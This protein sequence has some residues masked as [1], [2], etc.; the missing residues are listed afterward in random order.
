MAISVSSDFDYQKLLDIMEGEEEAVREIAMVFIDD[1]P[2]DL[3]ALGHAVNE[4]DY[5]Q[6]KYWAHKLKSSVP[7]FVPEPE[8]NAP[9]ALE[10]MARDQ[11]PWS[12]IETHYQRLYA[13][14]QRT[15]DALK[16]HFD[17]T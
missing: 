5:V 2:Q 1:V 8:K 10:F 14:A 16:Q 13:Q 6:T 9:R 11:H 17:L 15:V 7:N 4:R 3:Q 12:D